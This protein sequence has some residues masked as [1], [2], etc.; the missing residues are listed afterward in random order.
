MVVCHCLHWSPLGSAGLWLEHDIVDCDCFGSYCDFGS[1]SAF[2]SDVVACNHRFIVHHHSWLRRS[3][4]QCYRR[5]WLL[6]DF[7]W[8]VCSILRLHQHCHSDCTALLGCLGCKLKLYRHFQFLD[9]PDHLQATV[10]KWN[11]L[12]GCTH[13]C[14]CVASANTRHHDTSSKCGR[15]VDE[16]HISCHGYRVQFGSHCFHLHPIKLRRCGRMRSCVAHGAASIR[17]SWYQCLVGW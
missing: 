5:R 3:C 1:R 16:R 13:H 10:C 6:D 8:F 14:T 17:C 12:S 7:Q 2:Y 11:S 15:A 9:Q 4:H